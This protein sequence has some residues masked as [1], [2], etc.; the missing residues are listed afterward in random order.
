MD[1]LGE[2]KEEKK[3]IVLHEFRGFV[4]KWKDLVENSGDKKARIDDT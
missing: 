3:H 1:P 4:E 2:G